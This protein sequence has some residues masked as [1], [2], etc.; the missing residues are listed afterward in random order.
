M[1]SA[2]GKK[3]S[4][5]PLKKVNAVQLEH[6]RLE[7]L[8]NQMALGERVIINQWLLAALAVADLI[9]HSIHFW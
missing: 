5:A 6:A 7:S 9:A 2:R 8:S 1:P 4:R 3:S